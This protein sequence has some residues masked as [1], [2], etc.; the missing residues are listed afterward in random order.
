MKI[1]LLPT[2]RAF[3]SITRQLHKLQFNYCTTTSLAT[4]TRPLLIKVASNRTDA[5]CVEPTPQ[6]EL[7]YSKAP[8]SPP[9]N[10]CWSWPGA[11]EEKGGRRAAQTRK[12]RTVRGDPI[13]AAK[14]PPVTASSCIFST[15]VCRGS[16]QT[17]STEGGRRCSIEGGFP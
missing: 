5:I 16:W 15:K 9:C 14:I 17:C 11:S 1:Q 12:F 4:T 3:P 8:G 10:Q 2:F 13:N 6:L 7:S